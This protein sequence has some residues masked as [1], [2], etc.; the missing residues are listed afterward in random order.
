[1]PRPADTKAKRLKIVKA[2][3]SQ[4][5]RRGFE[6]TLMDDVAAAAHVSKGSLYDYFRNK[7]D[8]FYAVFEWLRELLL[9]AGGAE[10]KA[11]ASAREIIAVFAEGSVR[12]FVAHIELYPVMLD[13]W[14]AAA[15][16][17]TRKRFAKAMRELYGDYR[18]EVSALLRAAQDGG[19]I[20]KDAQVDVLASV[21]IGAVDGILLQYWLDPSF[22]ASGWVRIFLDELFEGVGTA[23]PEKRQ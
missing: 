17:G 12:A 19:E 11:G 10:L 18:R 1:M 3:A 22:D 23:K 14:A 7:E 13:V 15:K 21:L 8:L 5:A 6:A 20:R 4:F 9:H 2:A 16:T